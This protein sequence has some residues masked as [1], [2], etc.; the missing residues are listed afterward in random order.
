MELR[1][2]VYTRGQLSQSL[3]SPVISAV[4]VPMKFAEDIPADKR[5]RAILLPP[6]YLADCEDVVKR[7]LEELH[8]LGF[9]SALAHTVG[10]IELL[11]ECGYRI[12]GGNRLNCTNSET[13]RFLADSGVYDII[14]SPEL[15]VKRINKLDKPIPAGFIAYGHLPL[16][17]CRRCPISDGKPCGKENC[18][19]SVTDRLGKKFSVICSENTVEILNPDVLMLSGKLGEFAADFA[20]LRFTT[21]TDTKDMIGMFADNAEKKAEGYT[22]GTY[23]RGVQ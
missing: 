11:R 9:E 12:C 17:L 7:R 8:D 10:H 3:E 22:K 4:Y 19:R 18:G 20:V 16:M 23:Y 2:W 1:A 15:T 5:E 13:M 6:E 21:E 14:V